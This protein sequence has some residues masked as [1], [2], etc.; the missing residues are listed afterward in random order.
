[1]S[2]CIINLLLYMLWI[3]VFN[4]LAIAM[5]AWLITYLLPIERQDDEIFDYSFNYEFI[6]GELR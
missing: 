6:S 3:R 1:M 2:E 4:L 5:R